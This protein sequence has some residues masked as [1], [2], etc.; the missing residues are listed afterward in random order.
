MRQLARWLR[1]LLAALGLVVLVVTF[2]PLVSWWARAVSGDWPDPKGDVLIVLGAETI[3][4][5]TIGLVSY[6]RSVYAGWVY[7][8]GGFREVVVSGNQVAPLMRDFLVCRGVP[9]SAIRVENTSTS[10]RENAVYTAR[11]LAGHPGRLVLVSG[12]VHIFR[13]RRAFL[14]AGLNVVPCPFA[15]GTKLA[16]RRENRWNVFIDLIREHAKIG[17]YFAR[18]WI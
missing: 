1:W 15:Y 7:H 13:A 3:D 10:T 4:G 14:K 16:G 5:R 6:W 12:D 11:M 8:G 9:A 18:G 17:Y 2:T